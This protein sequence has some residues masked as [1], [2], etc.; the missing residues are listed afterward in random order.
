MAASSPLGGVLSLSIRNAVGVW[1]LD[2]TG[3]RI[4]RL[5]VVT[6]ALLGNALLSG[7]LARALGGLRASPSF[8]P[9]VSG[10]VTSVAVAWVV[11]TVLFGARLTFQLPLQLLLHLPVTFRRL[12][13]TRILCAL[14]G[15]WLGIFLPPL[16][17]LVLSTGRSLPG[18]T[19][20]VVGVLLFA[21]CVSE[22]STV[23]SLTLERWT[24][25]R[26]STL[27][28]LMLLAGGNYAY[29]SWV[30]RGTVPALSAVRLALE[31]AGGSKMGAWTALLPTGLLASA[32]SA[33]GTRE[34]LAAVAGLAIWLCG[35]AAV[36][37]P[38][39]LGHVLDRPRPAPRQP[40]RSPVLR[41]LRAWT[42]SDYGRRRAAYAALVAQSFLCYVRI[43]NIRLLILCGLPYCV[44]FPAFLRGDQMMAPLVYSM[45]WVPIMFFV[46]VKTNLL[47]ADPTAVRPCFWYP[48][49]PDRGIRAKL[50]A[51]NILI[52]FLGAVMLATIALATPRLVSFV[53]VTAVLAYWITQVGATDAFC[54][55][56]SVMAPKVVV[57]GRAAP[58]GNDAQI[59]AASGISGGIALGFTL[60]SLA[61]SWLHTP[62][63]LLVGAVLAAT[64]ALSIRALTFSRVLPR[65]LAERRDQM[66]R[67]LPLGS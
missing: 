34:T 28:L 33:T 31:A 30:T 24:S 6:I 21:L 2:T 43:A 9:L 27:L 25:S 15:S 50:T 1:R 52:T 67:S 65:L 38:V 22:F 13:L 54:A 5:A 19:V 32:L 16:V 29:F 37:Y 44:A 4:T 56:A 17:A 12:H 62:W 55:S 18:Q 39:V 53:S 63:L 41:L 20:Q 58:S 8:A 61:A 64:A 47:G 48:V 3:Q 42:S 14:G 66:W 45:L 26:T 23:L 59:F 46:A 40:L 10:I 51:V 35:L 60:L 57:W 11:T 7:A 49:S 36:S